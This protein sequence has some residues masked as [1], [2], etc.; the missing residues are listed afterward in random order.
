LKPVVVFG[1]FQQWG[2]DFIGEIHPA[3]SGQ[4]RWI[5]TATD[6]FTKWIESIPTR[7]VPHKVITSFLEDIMSIFGCPIKIVTDNAA[8][9]NVEP[10]IKLCEQYGIT[11]FHY[12]PYHP[13]G[14]GFL[15][16]SNKSLIKIIK[17]FLEDNKKACD[18][19][20]K[21]SLWADRVTTKRSLGV[22]PF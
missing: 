21:F 10:L 4:R 1:P 11:L 5:L 13:Q 14:N 20:M 12:T 18:S 19:K 2:I 9:F 6:Y 3:S 8:S 15:D 17:K 16:S 22:S 7:S